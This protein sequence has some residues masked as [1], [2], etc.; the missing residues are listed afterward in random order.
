MH[1]IAQKNSKLTIFVSEW[2]INQVFMGQLLYGIYAVI[3]LCNMFKR[4]L[5]RKK[6]LNALDSHVLLLQELSLDPEAR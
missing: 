2:W 1:T 6:G 4:I 3:T 5:K